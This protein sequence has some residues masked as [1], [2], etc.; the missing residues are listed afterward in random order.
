M[1]IYDTDNK[2][3]EEVSTSPALS[4]SNALTYIME[5]AAADLK[6]G[7]EIKPS[8]D[9]VSDS[10]SPEQWRPQV[11]TKEGSPQHYTEISSVSMD[12]EASIRFLD[13]RTSFAADESEAQRSID[14]IFLFGRPQLLFEFVQATMML[15]SLYISLWITNYAFWVVPHWMKVRQL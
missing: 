6:A 13:K 11:T 7:L 3:D 9:L 10:S 4:T 5:D 14:D 2:I 15:L 12:R 1:P 8:A